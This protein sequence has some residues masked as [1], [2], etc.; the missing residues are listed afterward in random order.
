MAGLSEPHT[1]VRMNTK[2]AAELLWFASRTWAS[3]GV[4]FLM[5]MEWGRSDLG[6]ISVTMFTDASLKGLG[7]WFLSEHT[8]FHS[9]VPGESPSGIIFFFEALAVVCGIWLCAHR[10]VFLRQYKHCR[11][12]CFAKC[13]RAYQQP[14]MFC[15]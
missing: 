2:I 15:R 4:H 12:F 1:R 13:R 6:D 3:T 11:R 7:I 9:L 5:S 8:G 14:I 10:F